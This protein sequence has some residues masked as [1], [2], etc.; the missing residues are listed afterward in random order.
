[1]TITIKKGIDNCLYDKR[2]YLNQ[3]TRL[4]AGFRRKEKVRRTGIEP[5]TLGLKALVS[6]SWFR[7]YVEQDLEG[8]CEEMDSHTRSVPKSSSCMTRLSRLGHLLSRIASWM[9]DSLRPARMAS[10]WLL[11]FL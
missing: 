3:K 4:L 1:M 5:E 2:C 9:S 11:D 10:S 7:S 8:E 6:R